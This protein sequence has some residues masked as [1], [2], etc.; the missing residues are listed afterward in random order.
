MKTGF[1]CTCLFVLVLT[2]AACAPKKTIYS[3]PGPAPAPSTLPGHKAQDP[4][5]ALQ[6][7]TRHLAATKPGDPGRDE[8]WQQSVG[9]A[10]QLGEYDLAEK[11]LRDWQAESRNATQSWDWNQ[12]NAQLLLARKGQDAYTSYLVE[13]ISRQDLDWTTRE[14]AGLE[15]SDHFWAMPEPGLAFD[16]LGLLYKSAPDDATRGPLEAHALSRAES[17]PLDELGRILA[18]NPGADPNTYPWSMVSWAQGMKLLAQDKA[19]WAAVWPGLSAIVR[20]GGLANKEFFAGNLRSLEQQMGVVRQSLV[21]LLPLSGPYS[22]VGW[23][24]ANG[25]NT[26]WRESMAQTSAP[27]I[28]LINTESPTF[29]DELR[30]ASGA[31]I[32]GGP[33]RREIW[34][35]IRMAGLHQNFKFMTF[36]PNVEDEGREAWRFFSSPADQV[37]TLIQG[38]EQLDIASFAILHP[39]DRFGVSMTEVFRNEARALGV[40]VPVVRDYDIA[41]P[42]T[43]GKAVA[44]LLGASGNK[45]AMNPEPPFQAVFL[46]DS[47]FRVQQLA[48]LFHYYEE[49][50]LIVLGPQLWTQSV[51]ESK[52]EMQYFD[53]T[54][55]PGA[56]NQ[57]ATSQAAQ[58]LKQ[59]LPAGEQA[60][61][62]TALGYDFVRFTALLGGNHPTPD[63]FNQALATASGRMSWCLAPMHWD[64]GRASQDL[65]LFQPTATGM[66]LADPAKIREIRD[67]RQL[68]RDQRRNQLQNQ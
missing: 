68:R 25:A 10:V 39:Q 55:F 47:L 8:A 18:S 33:L 50:R 51:A 36:L 59:S 27:Q 48:P 32:V 57:D 63:A 6:K 15:L 28:K 20:T 40:Q 1:F 5:K 44:A 11:N 45:N 38:C 2:L 12:A 61:L 66:V 65:F 4:Q 67:Q 54:I 58:N 42:P 23:K 64:N 43:W 13:L 22:Q 62:W 21:L 37:R 26:A 3:T 31:P 24:I 60:D 7:Y 34:Q 41:N 14:A 52:L 19:N 9:S 53:L 35:Q 49:T 16:A 17:L 46:P 29:L 30:A 56:W